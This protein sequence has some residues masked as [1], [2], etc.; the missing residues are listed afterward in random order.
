MNIL[1]IISLLLLSHALTGQQVVLDKAKVV[2]LTKNHVV[3][4]AT[5]TSAGEDAELLRASRDTIAAG[6]TVLHALQRDIY[7]HMSR[8]PKTLSS[9]RHLLHCGK[10]T[11][12]IADLQWEILSE[13]GTNPQ[14]L[15]IATALQDALAERT[16]SL[17]TAVQ[18]GVLGEGE[19]NLLSADQRLEWV[20]HVLKELKVMRGIS[21][22]VLRRMKLAK[23]VGLAQVMPL[24]FPDQDAQA[25]N[26]LLNS[27][28]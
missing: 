20:T 16:V 18:H 22:Q 14:L 2:E 7:Q 28:K 13:A 6:N 26:S 15:L 12:E 21:L 24:S 9:G 3:L 10:V 27:V 19:T 11:R 8:V 25:V 5:L 4:Y 1:R 17:A 23:R